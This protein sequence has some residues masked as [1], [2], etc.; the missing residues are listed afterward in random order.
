MVHSKPSTIPFGLVACTLSD[1]LSR[2]SC[3]LHRAITAVE[4]TIPRAANTRTMCVTNVKRKTTWLKYVE[5]RRNLKSNTNVGTGQMVNKELILLQKAP[6][7][8]TYMR[9]CIICP[10]IDEIVQSGPGTLLKE[11]HDRNH[12]WCFEDDIK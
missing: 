10:G 9:P 5:E 7:K 4:T 2:N 11:K 8:T 1:N 6:I 12:H 3:I